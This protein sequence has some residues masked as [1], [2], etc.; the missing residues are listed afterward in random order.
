MNLDNTH[1][2]EAIWVYLHGELDDAV[3]AAFE[4]RLVEDGALRVRYEQARRLDGTLHTALPDL[5]T[6]WFSDAA[7]AEQAAA[8]WARDQDV[9]ESAA[10]ATRSVTARVWLFRSLSAGGAALAA[11]LLVF[12]AFPLLRP[13]QA[14]PWAPVTF[15]PLVIRGPAAASRPARLREQDATRAQATLADSLA[16]ALDD[17]GGTLPANLSLSL[18]VRELPNGAFS[19]LVRAELPDGRL[20]GEWVGDYSSLDRFMEDA[21]ASAARLAEAIAVPP[22]AAGGQKARPGE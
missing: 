4:Q 3:Q 16:W 5:D 8:A 22:A 19:A 17:C 7:L 21:D 2:D 6:A 9:R 10:P 1:P 14:E 12:A 11:A 13:P 18:Q 15:V 20:L